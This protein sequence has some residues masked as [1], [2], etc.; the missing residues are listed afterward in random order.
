MQVQ[1]D[2]EVYRV[3]AVWLGPPRLTFPWRVRYVSY[4]L[5]LAVLVAVLAVQRWLDVPFG[6]LPTGWALVVTVAVVRTVGHRIDDERPL[7]H[8]ARSWWTDVRT[9]RPPRVR[10]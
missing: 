7:R 10:A 6:L 9:P 4:A 3:D 1:T 2:D 5:G 8:L